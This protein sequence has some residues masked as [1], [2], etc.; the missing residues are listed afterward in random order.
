MDIHIYD[1]NEEIENASRR[2]SQHF[3]RALTNTQVLYNCTQHSGQ[4]FYFF[5]KIQII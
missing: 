5:Y 3:S 2:A 1:F 4:V